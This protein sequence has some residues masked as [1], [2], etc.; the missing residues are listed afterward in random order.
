MRVAIIAAAGL[1]LAAGAAQI[2]SRAEEPARSVWDGVYTAEQAKRGQPLY[3]KACG[4][5]H[6]GDLSGGE[7][8]PPLA[9][10]EFMSNWTG[11]TVGEL[12]ERIRIT[13]PADKPGK[14]SREVNA[15]ILAYMLEANRFPAG[16]V[17]LP[18]ATELLKQIK[19]EA[20]KPESKK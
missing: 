3:V 15:D 18:R 17:E 11:L 7:S 8:A 9:G 20:S 14:L 19:I 4:S 12:F 16:A 6:A 1:M 5:C 13:M 2:V 10:G